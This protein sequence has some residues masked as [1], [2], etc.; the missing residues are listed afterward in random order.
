MIDGVIKYN[1]EFT[2]T[3]SKL[4]TN[5]YTNLEAVRSRL[6]ALRLIGICEGIGYGNISLKE[7]GTFHITGTQTG[8]LPRLTEEEYATVTAYSFESFVLKAEGGMKPSSEAFSHAMIYEISPKIGAVIHIHS[9]PLW[10]YMIE[11][12]Y[13]YT[14]AEY[15]TQKMTEEIGD[16]FVT[17][18]PFE[19][20]L[21]VMKGHEDGVMVFGKSLE[22]AERTLYELVGNFLYM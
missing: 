14:E 4:S 3:D 7:E 2:P 17:K 6:F 16:L 8:H 22:E 1:I 9:K 15:G 20:P 10:K 19:Q 12:N 5:A 18:D 21:F 13:S 11:N